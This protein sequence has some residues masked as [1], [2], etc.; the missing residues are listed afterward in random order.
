MKINVPTRAATIRLSLTLSLFWVPCIVAQTTPPSPNLEPQQG[1]GQGEF[2][3][4]A[5]SNITLVDVTVTDAKGQPVHGLPQSA[6]TILEDGKPQPIRSFAEIG[7]DTPM[8]TRVPPQLPPNVHTNVQPTPTTSAV[9]VLLLDSLN[10]SPADQ[11]FVKDETMRYLKSMAPGTRIA[12]M[13]LSSKLRL[14]QGFTTDP[15]I[16]LA[17]VDTKKNRALPSPFMDTDTGDLTNSLMDM[18]D[19]D[20][21]AALQEFQNEQNSFQTDMRNRMTMEALDQ[22]AAYLTGIKGRKNLIWF[23]G[24]MPLQMFPQGG[25]NDLAAMT[26]YSKDLRKTTDLLTA[27]QIAVYP[28]DARGLMTNPANSVVSPP[29][30][31]ANGKGDSAA[32]ATMAFGMK[33]AQE[34]LGMEAV[35]EATGGVAF[36]NTN[37]LKEAVRDAINNGQNYYTLS[38]VPP[39]PAFDGA[40]HNIT[41]KLNPAGYHLSYRK[42]YYADDIAKNAITPGITLAT[43]APEPY[44]NN[45]QASMGRGVPTSSQLL[46]SARVEPQTD[47]VNPPGAKVVGTLDPKLQSK[48]RRRYTIQYSLPGRQVTFK[49]APDGVRKGTLEFDIAAYDVYGKVISTLSQ[50]IDLS[51]TEDRYQLLQ[52]KP[53]QLTQAIDLPAG[54]VFLRVGI[55]DSVSDK[56]GTMEI[57]LSVTRKSTP[58][59][60]VATHP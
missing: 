6:F 52:K 2:T 11:I 45:M 10:T 42:G 48:P 9:N 36:Y 26:D 20:T 28:V 17:A 38:Y 47:S 37:G 4:K 29:T 24:G 49:E 13:G 22:I 33:S 12:I 31:F 46:F 18:A 39:S 27:A 57:P 32:K 40:F 43:T 14:L 16:L 50:S 59:T 58:T 60:P 21:A 3:L 25:T 35:A 1:A 51:L 44:G 56:T 5:Y 53:F 23:T 34:H 15:A 7:K 8:V 41:V 30:G 55:L 19:A 54:E